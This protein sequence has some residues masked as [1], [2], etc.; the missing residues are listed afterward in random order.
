MHLDAFSK[1]KWPQ[2]CLCSPFTPC[3]F[4]CRMERKYLTMVEPAILKAVQRVE[5]GH[6]EEANHLSN[7]IDGKQAN[8]HT[9][10]KRQHSHIWPGGRH[11]CSFISRFHKNNKKNMSSCVQ[12]SGTV[13]RWTPK[14]R[15]TN[16]AS[17][18]MRNMVTFSP[19]FMTAADKEE[20]NKP[21]KVR[22]N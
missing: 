7:G 5:Q 15:V 12:P 19:L 17:D 10:E 9:L 11:L 2:C 21:H 1:H 6:V 8:N 20:W 22:H 4:D 13:L 3:Y 16:S 18:Q 14:I